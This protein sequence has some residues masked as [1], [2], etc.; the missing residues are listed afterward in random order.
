MAFIDLLLLLSLHV[1][2]DLSH[3]LIGK[4]DVGLILKVI[5]R[6]LYAL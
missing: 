3:L 5:N 1:L 6:I 4:S 2:E